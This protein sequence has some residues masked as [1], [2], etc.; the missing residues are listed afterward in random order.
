MTPDQVLACL[1]A[2]V[3]AHAP[4]VEV[5]P[6]GG[7]LPSK[8]PLDSQFAAPVIEAAQLSRGVEPYLVPSSGGSL[9]NYAFTNILGLPA[10]S[11]PYANA[12]EANHAPNENM[13]VSLFHAGIRNGAALLHLLGQMQRGPGGWALPPAAG[14]QIA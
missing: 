11:T 9:P 10:F 4:E 7:M 8:T 14:G 1:R 3:A 5:V 2:H 12:D 13:E 6:R